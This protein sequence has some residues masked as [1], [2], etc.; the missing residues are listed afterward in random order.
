M[1]AEPWGSTDWP[2][3][4]LS[5]KTPAARTNRRLHHLKPVRGTPSHSDW[6][7]KAPR[8]SE[9]PT[10]SDSAPPWHD[11]SRAPWH[12]LSSPWHNPPGCPGRRSAGPTRRPKGSRPWSSTDSQA[13]GDRSHAPATPWPTA[14]AMADSRL[15]DSLRRRC[16]PEWAGKP[17]PR[18]R[19][20]PS[21]PPSI[22]RVLCHAA[23]GQLGISPIGI[24]ATHCGAMRPR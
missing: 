8:R 7:V 22:V 17:M 24:I 20:S 16:H 21:P 3:S 23:P 9:E 10:L 11:E 14:P 12:G 4:S 2:R 1:S 19:L 15:E 5:L 18:L 6:G 13:A